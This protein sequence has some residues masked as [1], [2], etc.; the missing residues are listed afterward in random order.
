MYAAVYGRSVLEWMIHRWQDSSISFNSTDY[1]HGFLIPMVS[2][3]VVWIRRGELRAAEK[4][5]SSIGLLLLICSLLLHWVG[6]K[7]QHPRLS[8]VA[9]MGI[10]WTVPFYLYG[11]TVARIL[12]FPCAYLIFCVPLN[13]LD[14]LTQPLQLIMVDASSWL[15]NGLGFEVATSGT[16]MK[17]L[18]TGGIF[19]VAAPCSGLRSL[20]AMTALTA[21]Y[22]YFTQ[23]TLIRQGLLFCC[24]IPLAIAG[25]IARV[26]S[27]VLV[28]EVAGEEFALGVYHDYAGFLVFAVGIALM[29]AVGGA[30]DS[31]PKEWMEKWKTALSGPTW[32]P[33][34]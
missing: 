24:S 32:S 5:V 20:L 1:S 17:L 22:A 27:I 19:S 28:A 18:R 25:N 11:W 4:R 2:A 26:V 16:D 21:V 14:D 12:F 10:L 3:A 15:L 9:L 31:D 7:S 23:K 33:S 6:A 13:F 30:L 8:L 29:V 34:S